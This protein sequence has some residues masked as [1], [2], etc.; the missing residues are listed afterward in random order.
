MDEF[1]IN[2]ERRKRGEVVLGLGCQAEEFGLKSICSSN[3]E[4]FLII[5]TKESEL[6]RSSENFEAWR[7][8]QGV[9]SRVV[10][11][12][13]LPTSDPGEWLSHQLVVRSCTFRMLEG[14][15]WEEWKL[16]YPFSFK[17]GKS[18]WEENIQISFCVYVLWSF[19]LFFLF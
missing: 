3:P 9:L 17:S 6:I 12:Y 2:W 10:K 19:F 5:R 4:S 11:V 15:Q 14:G 13:R 18:S 16:L 7:T 8:G 1:E